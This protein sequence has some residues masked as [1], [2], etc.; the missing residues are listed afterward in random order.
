MSSKCNAPCSNMTSGCWSRLRALAQ[1]DKRCGVLM[2]TAALL[3]LLC[4][5]LPQTSIWFRQVSTW[6]PLRH[7]IVGTVPGL[8]MDLKEWVQDGLLTAF[9]LVI[10]LELRQESATGTLHDPRQALL[11]MLAAVGG[12]AAPISIYLTVN[13]GNPSGM[14]G[15]AVP[16]AT[17]VAF[18]LAALR[19]LTPHAGVELQAFLMTLA[20]FDDIIGVLLIAAGYSHLERPW[21]LI[22]VIICLIAWYMLTRRPHIRWILALPMAIGS[23]YGMLLTGIHPVLSGVA[24]GLLT[25]G[26]PIHGEHEPRAERFARNMAPLSA[27]LALPLFAF[28]SMGIPLNGFTPSW[29]VDPIFIGITVGLALGKPLGIMAMLSICF[30]LGLRLSPG[31]HMKD[32]A[33]VAQLCGIGFTMSFLIANLAFTDPHLTGMA[34]MAVLIGSTLSCLLSTIIITARKHMK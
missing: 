25:P 16:T 5:N 13:I 32:L 3:G 10:G 15:W 28:L 18:S 24:L 30:R 27:L 6:I 12:V 2:L 26:N 29:L 23:W 22:P 19:I 8:G 17:D 7:T 34:L 20:V 31:I 1:D 4:A 21:L 11:P 33:G 14:G 9:F